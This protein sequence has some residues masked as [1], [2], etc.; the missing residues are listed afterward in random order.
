M[1]SAAAGSLYCPGE[2]LFVGGDVGGDEGGDVGVV[3]GSGVTHAVWPAFALLPAGHSVHTLAFGPEI[4]P[5]AHFMHILSG[6][7]E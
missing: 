2:Q 7:G 6:E 4:R 1:H 3:V 5:A